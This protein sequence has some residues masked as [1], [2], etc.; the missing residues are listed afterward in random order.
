MTTQPAI[1]I[2]MDRARRALCLFVEQWCEQGVS[3]VKVRV[4]TKNE[5][6]EGVWFYGRVGNTWKKLPETVES[7][8]LALLIAMELERIAVSPHTEECQIRRK[9]YLDRIEFEIKFHSEKIV[10]HQGKQ[11]GSYLFGI[12]FRERHDAPDSKRQGI[13][14]GGKSRV[15]RV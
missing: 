3:N 10:A 9:E 6:P 15:A 4:N 1:D 13:R 7:S 14:R 12:L 11:L 5:E 2:T 8:E